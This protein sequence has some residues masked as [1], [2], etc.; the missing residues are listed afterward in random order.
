M[1]YWFNAKKVSFDYDGTLSTAKGKEL[2]KS[3]RGTVYI[4]SA[5]SSKDGMLNTAESLGIPNSR[6]YATG[7]NEAKI[8]KIKELGID[9]HYD[10]NPDVINKLGSVGELFTS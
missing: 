10:N 4:I 8:A 3:Q 2:A 9:V 6:V 1:N 7:S 5:R